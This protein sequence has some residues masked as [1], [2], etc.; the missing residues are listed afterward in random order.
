MQFV[1]PQ[2]FTEAVR[3]LGSRSLITSQLTSEQWGRVPVALRERAF[4]SSRVESAQFLQR[5]RNSIAD[6]VQ[7]HRETL[8]NGE[9]ALKTGSRAD[10]IKQMQDFAL[11]NG[12]GEIEPGEE[13]GAT[14][15][16][17]K[18]TNLASERRL[19]LIFDTQTRQAQDFGYWQQGQ[20][21]DVLDAFPAQR[22]IRVQ[23]VKEPRDMHQHH[24]GE[25]HLKSDL[26]FWIGLN[27]DFGVPWGPWGWGCGHDV[28]D[29]D[30]AE[31]ERLGLLKPGEAVTPVETE[32]NDHLQASVQS[33]DPELQ[34][35][36]KDAFGNQVKFQ[37]DAVWWKGD[38]QGK[39]L[40][41]PKPEKPLT[42]PAPELPETDPE[43][44]ASLDNLETVRELG[45]STGATLVRPKGS[46][47]LFV[48]KRGAS[49]A[50][51]QEETTADDLYRALG[52]SVP[53]SRL[54]PGGSRPAKLSRFI[55]GETL[56]SRL[57]KAS[58]EEKKVLL[59][60]AQEH[61]AADALL[62]NWDVAGLNLDNIVVDK[63]GTPWRIDNGGALRFRAQGA[64]KTA[65]QWDEFA[66]ELWSMR[67]PAENPQTARLFEGLDIFSVARQVA[68]I[69]EDKLLAAAPAD[70]LATLQGRLR[71]L[72]EIGTKA[73]EYE[74]TNFK[75]LHADR[76]TRHMMGLRKINAFD[77][78]ATELKQS[79][80]GDV[81]PVDSEGNPFDL[82]R[83]N[84]AKAKADPSQTFYED[85]L[86]AAKTINHHHEQGNLGY[87]MA[88]LA[89]VAAHKSSLF[90][91]AESGTI[92]EKAMA[93]AY[94]D[95]INKIEIAQGNLQAKAPTVA[96]INKI[97]L[98]PNTSKGAQASSFVARLADYMQS[99]GGDWKFINQWASGQAGSTDSAASRKLSSWLLKRLDIPREE[100]FAETLT[101]IEL[102][103]VEERSFEIY[104]AA[105]QELLAR[106][107]F[108]GN[109]Q[110]A[111][112]LRV[113]RTETQKGVV[114]MKKGQAADYKRK[115]NA[116]G[117]IFAPVFSGTRTVTVVPH[118]RVTG[119]YFLERQPGSAES[120][121][122]GDSENEITYIGQRLKALNLGV[123][124]NVNLS[125]GKDHAQWEQL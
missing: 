42:A 55:D 92:E 100:F 5:A 22:F 80:P 89:K 63:A 58:A 123:N 96:K 65:E 29:V 110:K 18:L 4:F 57:Q 124:G 90:K 34:K 119:V 75:A 120:F 94:L 45:G 16:P 35:E 41:V 74:S 61:F 121:F 62:G 33:L 109:D 87:N 27:A 10:F 107:E 64:K 20:D 2:P 122:L 103:Q 93:S 6:F 86:A 84:K 51:I 47:G 21:P 53:E 52:V 105:I 14:K 60:K 108:N 116:S 99:N 69:A 8:D 38:R 97:S 54:Y 79:H 70:L 15:V 23:P 83:T 76:V 66:T 50:H 71:N 117:S 48:L 31:A 17:N 24:E 67:N 36:L 40:A 32:F 104:H 95:Y 82:L 106:V 81:R 30:R 11:S 26:Q 102:T 56:A 12:L 43:F 114:P 72:K 78:V 19:G 59:A 113:L 3:K 37:G 91:L 28:E 44:P 115:V 118:S 1:K 13:E 39:T 125:P 112:L 88:K 49:A 85:I 111:R 73:L 68:A 9:T 7:V 101:T 77:G 25:V 98:S 46:K